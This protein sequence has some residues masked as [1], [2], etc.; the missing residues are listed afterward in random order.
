MKS[1]KYLKACLRKY[2][3]TGKFIFILDICNLRS[4]KIW[5]KLLY[6]WLRILSQS[7]L[8]IYKVLRNPTNLYFLTRNAQ[9]IMFYGISDKFLA[10]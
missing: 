7:K 4:K 8:D 3:A 6:I 2:K 1:Q 10:L 9:I 5:D